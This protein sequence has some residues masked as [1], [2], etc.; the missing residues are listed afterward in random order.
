MPVFPPLIGRSFEQGKSI[1]FLTAN[2][3]GRYKLF[4]IA[5]KSFT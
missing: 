3:E 5:E 2:E 1:K 4:S